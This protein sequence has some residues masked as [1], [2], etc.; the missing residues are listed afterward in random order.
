MDPSKIDYFQA[1]SE[2][3]ASIGSPWSEEFQKSLYRELYRVA[4]HSEA[5]AGS[6][7]ESFRRIVLRATTDEQKVLAITETISGIQKR[8][9]T[10]ADKQ[11]K[12]NKARALAAQA[13]QRKRLEKKRRKA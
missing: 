12:H 9:E 13:K 2:L 10:R 8:L 6:I 5:S 7:F 1:I 3:N 4:K 11:P